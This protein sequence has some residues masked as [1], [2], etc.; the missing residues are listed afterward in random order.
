MRLTSCI[1]NNNTIES[2]W[3]A[4]KRIENGTKPTYK[5][6]NTPTKLPRKKKMSKRREKKN[7]NNS[8]TDARI[9][10][11]KRVD[12]F[13]FLLVVSRTK[14]AEKRS[15]PQTAPSVETRFP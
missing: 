4:M 8:L 14:A 3:T 15:H 13:A 7:R 10:V 12:S 11:N 9:V 1:V 6:S 5:H 2:V